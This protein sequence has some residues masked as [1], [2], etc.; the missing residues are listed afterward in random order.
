MSLSF[1][2]PYFCRAWPIVAI[3]QWYSTGGTRTGTLI[4]FIP[5]YVWVFQV[6]FSY[7]F[8]S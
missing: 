3:M 1:Q 2:L 5:I 6:N 4:Y 7:N 8:S